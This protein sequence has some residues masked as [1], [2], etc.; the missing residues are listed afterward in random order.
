MTLKE[1]VDIQQYTKESDIK[2]IEQWFI[3]NDKEMEGI[4]LLSNLASTKANKLENILRIAQ[5]WIPSVP[6]VYD[7][8][9]QKV[10]KEAAIKLNKIVQYHLLNMPLSNDL[11][12][13]AKETVPTMKTPTCIFRPAIEWLKN[14]YEIEFKD[15]QI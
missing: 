13:W 7:S 4:D 10:P 11:L 12:N 15:K 14:E 2:V 3:S 6:D 9:N 1:L 8:N 5:M